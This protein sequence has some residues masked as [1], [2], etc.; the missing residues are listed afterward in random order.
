MVDIPDSEAPRG[1]DYLSRE[2]STIEQSIGDQCVAMTSAII[3]RVDESWTV[4]PINDGV[5]IMRAAQCPHHSRHEKT[6]DL[7][8]T[9]RMVASTVL[10]VIKAHL[11]SLA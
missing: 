7:F 5:R 9:V 11:H 1:K 8:Q 4:L 6:A 2:G 3:E 10:K